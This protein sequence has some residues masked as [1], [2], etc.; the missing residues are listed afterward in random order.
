MAKKTEHG[1]EKGGCNPFSGRE[2]SQKFNKLD[3]FRETIPPEDIIPIEKLP[4]DPL[5][6]RGPG[7]LI[8]LDGGE[9][10]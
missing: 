1:Y 8:E 6:V 3:E 10:S 9:P 2:N 5:D 4:R 7:G